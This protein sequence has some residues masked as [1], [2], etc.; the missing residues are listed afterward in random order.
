MH[1]TAAQQHEPLSKSLLENWREELL[2]RG[3]SVSS[4]NQR[5]SAVRWLLGQAAD[6]GALSTEEA[7]RLAACSNVKQSR[8]RLGKWLNDKEAG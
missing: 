8:Q 3:L 4:V 5:L 6:R 7:Q 1:W 2:L